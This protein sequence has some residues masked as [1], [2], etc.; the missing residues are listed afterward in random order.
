[1]HGAI[2]WRFRMLFR[3]SGLRPEIHPSSKSPLIRCSNP[4]G[5]VLLLDTHLRVDS[6]MKE[7]LQVARGTGL[8]MRR[9]ERP[10]LSA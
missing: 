6:N 4:H 7:T 5:M 2:N 1:M 8:N 3:P 10:P 9:T